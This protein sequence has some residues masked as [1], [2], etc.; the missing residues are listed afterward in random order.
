MFIYQ[1]KDGTN[2][3]I[4]NNAND[5]I[6]SVSSTEDIHNHF[7]PNTICFH[8]KGNTVSHPNHYTEGRKIETIDYIKD[9]LNSDNHKPYE[10]YLLGNIVKYLSRY[11]RKGKPVEDLKKAVQYI[12]WL[13]KEQEDKPIE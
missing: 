2:P 11:K 6:P 7:H 3:A 13:I 12:E 5:V 4:K 10:A 9:L 8:G 1:T